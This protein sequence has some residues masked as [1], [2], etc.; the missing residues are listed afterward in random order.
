MRMSPMWLTSN[1]PTPERTALCSATSPPVEG[2]STGISQPPKLTIFAPARRCTAFSAV[3]RTSVE[4]G[5]VADS[6]RDAREKLILARALGRV[7]TAQQRSEI[8]SGK[9][10]A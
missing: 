8:G 9:N 2:Y 6:I 1:N 7:K 3:F 4:E 5:V 10:G